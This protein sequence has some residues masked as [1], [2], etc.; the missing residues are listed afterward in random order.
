M[1]KLKEQPESITTIRF[2]D[3]D[4]YGHLNNSKYLDYLIN[5]REDHLLEHYDFNMYQFSKE[6]NSSWVVSKN[7][8][9]YKYPATAFEKVL[10]RTQLIEYSNLKLK[11][12][13]VM[14][15]EK[16]QKL[17]ALLWMDMF[18]ID[19]KTLKIKKHSDDLLNLFERV[20]SPI[21]SKKIEERI[22]NILG[23]SK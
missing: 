19:F 10:I 12:E 23:T 18:F 21:E 13:M 7:E 9:I 8:I 17:K 11:I 1:K 4:P 15:D 22:K 2:Q 5:A 6:H 20:V 3:C 14:F 16:A